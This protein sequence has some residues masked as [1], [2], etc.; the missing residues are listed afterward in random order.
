MRISGRSRRGDALDDRPEARGV[1]VGVDGDEA[2]RQ[3]LLD[4]LE[5][6]GL[7]LGDG[8]VD[9]FVAVPGADRDADRAGVHE[10][11]VVAEQHRLLADREGVRAH[12][13]GDRAHGRRGGLGERRLRLVGDVRARRE[14][15]LPLRE[16]H[17]EREARGNAA[18]AAVRLGQL[19]EDL[20][21]GQGHIVSSGC[22]VQ[23]SSA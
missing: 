7:R 23:V 22:V 13:D 19:L 11:L 2:A 18:V 6:G 15:G 20:D 17:R 10:R 3:L 1:A 8:R 21:S 12:A 14:L 4:A 16:L 5:G 9:L